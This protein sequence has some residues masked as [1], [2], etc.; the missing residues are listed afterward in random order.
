MEEIKNIP[1][2]FI[3]QVY[4][5]DILGEIRIS[6]FV[7]EESY[8]LLFLRQLIPADSS[9]A[10]D[11]HTFLFTAKNIF[12]Y[13]ESSRNFTP[14]KNGVKYLFKF[15]NK[16]IETNS[17]IISSISAETN[18]LEDNLYSRNYPKHFMDLWFDLKKDISNIDRYYQRFHLIIQEFQKN[19]KPEYRFTNSQY[20]DLISAI[21]FNLALIK[22]EL[23]KLDILH[24]YYVSIKNDK[25]NRNIYLLTLASGLF[26]PL[27]LIVG[28]FG[29]NTQ[30]LFF[31]D[32]P[33]GTFY[34][35]YI[36][37]GLIA[38][39][40]LLFP[41]LRILDKLI[42]SYL[43]GRVGLYNKISK[44]MTDIVKSINIE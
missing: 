34:V 12:T 26:L 30:N 36:I 18:K 9:I 31:H 35:L 5:D 38:L 32:N 16:I 27:N 1:I 29:I 11:T 33:S 24:H 15:I 21:Q 3:D 20:Q 25:L 37:F 10:Y 41:I 42:L 2:E 40:V 8:Q 6:S 14:L 22:D 39:I 19:T 28:F 17:V 13:E 43:L 4:Q 23:S 44:K 7:Q